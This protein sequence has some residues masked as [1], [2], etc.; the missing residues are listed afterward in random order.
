[1]ARS[2]VAV[3]AIKPKK[4][5]ISTIRKAALDALT[6]EGQAI[7]AD[8]DETIAGWQHDKPTFKPK[9]KASSSSPAVQ[10][11]PTG[12]EKGVSKWHW[13]NGGTRIRWALM[14]PGW[15]SKTRPGTLL[16]RGGKG[17]V[18]IAGRKAMM[19]RGIAP[20]PGIEARKWG[21]IILANSRRRIGNVLNRLERAHKRLYG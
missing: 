11:E 1:M 14:T 5:N 18:R 8:F 2:F 9:V 13:L 7:K 6:E 16:T 19:R 20:R 21:S 17:G 15:K 4:M 3:R 10:V 12:N